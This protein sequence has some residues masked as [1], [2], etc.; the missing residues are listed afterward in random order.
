MSNLIDQWQQLAET[1]AQ[2]REPE[3]QGEVEVAGFRFVGRRL[4]FADW[5]RCGRVPDY[6]A[7]E[8]FRLG[9][10]HKLEPKSS[11]MTPED[12][13]HALRFQRELVCSVVVEPKIVERDEDLQ[14]GA[15]S[16]RDFAER[17]PHLVG[18]L[19]NWFLRGCPGIPVKVDGGEASVAEVENFRA[20]KQAGEPGKPR[21]T[22]KGVRG[23]AQQPDRAA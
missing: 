7:I 20:R 22:G 18:A 16:Y 2:E 4:N 13:R 19:V 8:V 6:L 21:R 1:A 3:P 5:V 14:P 15:I 11:D 12:Y 17:T 10:G 9:K 23:A